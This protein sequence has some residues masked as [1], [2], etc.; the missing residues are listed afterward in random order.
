MYAHAQVHPLQPTHTHTHNTH[1]MIIYK[2]K[3]IFIFSFVYINL[4]IYLWI[5][6]ITAMFPFCS[7]SCFPGVSSWLHLEF[8][9]LV[10]RSFAKA[11]WRLLHPF[12]F[13]WSIIHVVLYMHKHCIYRHSPYITT[14]IWKNVRNNMWNNRQNVCLASVCWRIYI[15]IYRIFGSIISICRLVGWT[16]GIFRLFVSVF[17]CVCVLCMEDKWCRWAPWHPFSPAH[18]CRSTHNPHARTTDAKPRCCWNN[19]KMR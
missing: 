13:P 6:W 11:S 18:L 1:H 9:I 8:T 10:V 5:I 7:F 15:Y 2:N 14:F 16:R 19:N 17:G 3:I 12:G 4:N